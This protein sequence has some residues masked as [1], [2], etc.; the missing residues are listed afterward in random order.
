MDRIA[1]LRQVE[2]ALAAFEAGET[3]LAGLER[4]VRATLRTYATDLEGD[5]R[6]YRAVGEPPAD[7]TVVLAPS[8]GAARERVAELV[9]ETADF[10]VERVDP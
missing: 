1:A 2:D 6:A 4:E 3:D 8:A 7:G 9:G 5:Q 10:E